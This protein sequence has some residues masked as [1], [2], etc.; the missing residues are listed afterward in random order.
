MFRNDPLVGP[1]SMI[2][3]NLAAQAY[4]GENDIWMAT[5]NILER[6]PGFV[7]STRPRVPNPADPAEDYA[8]KWTK[9]PD[10]LT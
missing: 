4:G 6:M 5:S 1:I 8:D 3:T 2:I 10:L 9:N 7:R